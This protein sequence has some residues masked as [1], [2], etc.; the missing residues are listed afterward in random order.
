[1]G[2]GGA[3]QFGAFAR[4]WGTLIMGGNGPY[5]DTN[6]PLGGYINTPPKKIDSHLPLPLLQIIDPTG[7]KKRRF[8]SIRVK[9]EIIPPWEQQKNKITKA[10]K[11]GK[12]E[13]RGYPT[14]FH[15]LTVC[16]T[17]KTIGVI[18][19]IGYEQ[20]LGNVPYFYANYRVFSTNIP[21]H[22]FQEKNG[23]VS[24]MPTEYPKNVIGLRLTHVYNRK[25]LKKWE[26]Y[27]KNPKDDLENVKQMMMNF[28]DIRLDEMQIISGMDFR[29][30][31]LSSTSTVREKAAFCDD[32]RVNYNQYESDSGAMAET[33]TVNVNRA[34]R[35]EPLTQEPRIY[36]ILSHYGLFKGSE[37]SFMSS[38]VHEAMHAIDSYRVLYL[39]NWWYK[40]NTKKSFFA[41][42][43]HHGIKNKDIT[44]Y[45]LIRV[46]EKCELPI[47]EYTGNTSAAFD[48]YEKY[49]ER[50][51]NKMF[52]EKEKKEL[53]PIKEDEIGIG[54]GSTLHFYQHLEAFKLKLWLID[55]SILVA[56]SSLFTGDL[57]KMNE[58]YFSGKH[59]K[60][61]REMVK[62]IANSINEIL[63][64]LDKEKKIL[65]RDYVSIKNTPNTFFSILHQTLSS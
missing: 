45:D 22:Y 3:N 4:R 15:A 13:F 47:K 28:M 29:N 7:I 61:T 39:I 8:K 31:I 17:L 24:F 1:M 12:L 56:H 20:S 52:S 18:A 5:T 23:L 48:G 41:W 32:N 10:K 55:K 53:S 62:E 46:L 44:H 26:E 16:S 33:Y 60:K 36:I 6:K 43:V 34:C 54:Y 19:N 64:S 40:S 2:G 11:N 27:L 63:N 38:I 51:Q 35:Q 65:V 25:N 58:F 42:I 9:E 21:K 14:L 49:K 50:I 37:I 30:L 59:I 57:D